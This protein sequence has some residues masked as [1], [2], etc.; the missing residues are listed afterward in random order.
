MKG[1]LYRPA[2]LKPQSEFV[3]PAVEIVRHS[4]PPLKKMDYIHLKKC[5][6]YLG[7]IYIWHCVINLSYGEASVHRSLIR[8]WRL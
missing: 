1:S 2:I 3:F 5:T 6:A 8:M 4:M 7:S